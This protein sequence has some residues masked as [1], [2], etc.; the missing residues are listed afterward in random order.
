MQEEEFLNKYY[1]TFKLI[2]LVGKNKVKLENVYD[3]LIEQLGKRL[4]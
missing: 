4:L 2:G 1:N 3:Y